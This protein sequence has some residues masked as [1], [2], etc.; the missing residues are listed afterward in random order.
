M[1]LQYSYPPPFRHHTLH[2]QDGKL[3]PSSY[4]VSAVG[5]DDLELAGRLFSLPFQAKE[6]LGSPLSYF[7]GTPVLTPSGAALGLGLGHG[8]GPHAGAAAGRVNWVEGLNAPLCKLPELK[9]KDPLLSSLRYCL[10]E[11]GT[12]MGRIATSLFH[13]VDEVLNLQPKMKR[14]SY[15]SESTG[16]V[17]VYRYPHCSQQISHLG[18]DVHT[19]SSMLTILCQDDVGGLKVI[20]D[21]NWTPVR[22]IP[23][24]LVINLGD[25]MQ[26]VSNDKFKS[27]IHKVKINEQK[28]RI[29]I[30]HFVFPGDDVVIQGSNYRPFKYKEFQDQVQRD[31]KTVGYKVGLQRFRSETE[32]SEMN[33]KGK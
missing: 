27:A 5:L 1:S 12:H 9:T 17:R 10:Q 6:L 8:V 16:F 3:Q 21:A 33:N 23:S 7:W 29:S 14:G 32:F 15:L 31:V 2:L 22:P 28:D 13:I 20:R 18:M 11:Y 19:D 26:V 30:G 4:P 24:T 25:M